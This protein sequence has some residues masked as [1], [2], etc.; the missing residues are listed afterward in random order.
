MQVVYVCVV[1]VTCPYSD[2][3]DEVL[4]TALLAGS[5][6]QWLIPR[7]LKGRHSSSSPCPPVT[8]SSPPPQMGPFI[9]PQ[10]TNNGH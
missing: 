4:H 6:C 1:C 9:S 8:P 2:P 7:S 5:M 10:N 3:I